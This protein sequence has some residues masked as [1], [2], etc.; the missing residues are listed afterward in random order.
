MASDWGMAKLAYEAAL[1]ALEKT[2]PGEVASKARIIE[3][4]QGSME[5]LAREHMRTAE[6]L[7][8]SGHEEDARELLELAQE[9]CQPSALRADIDSLLQGMDS[10]AP[11]QNPDQAIPPL[12]SLSDGDQ[13]N[14]AVGEPETFMALIGPLPDEAR[15]AYMSYGPTFREGYLALNQGDFAFAADALN[16][17]VEENPSPD[18]YIPLELATALLNLQRLGEARQWLETFLAHHPDALP[19]YQVLC[20][21]F[22]EMEAFD[23]AEALLEACPEELKN[24]LAFVLL[25]GES[26]SQAGRHAEAAA[27]Y[28]A[29]LNENGHHDAVLRA[30]AGSY[31]ALEKPEEARALYIQIMNQCRSCHTHVDPLVRR[32]FADISFDLNERSMP[33]LESYFSLAQEDPINRPFYYQRISD[34]Y[35]AMGNREQARRFQGFARQVTGERE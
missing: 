24:S 14:H 19:G 33:V 26:M 23:R 16:R 22:W 34:I 6:D 18:T 5:A 4:L 11:E 20:E 1:D 27:F 21:V 3:K 17:A 35:A 10:A 7:I 29:F 28:Q 12:L 31:E 32:K 15:R 25:R 13:E 2:A 9:L 30:L 8:E